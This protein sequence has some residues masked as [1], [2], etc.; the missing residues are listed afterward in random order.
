M[1]AKNCGG[2]KTS[3]V[4]LSVQCAEQCHVK[5]E[6]GGSEHLSAC[7][8]VDVALVSFHLPFSHLLY[9]A[10]LSFACLLCLSPCNNIG[11]CLNDVQ[12]RAGA[13]CH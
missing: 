3:T 9:L 8:E 2:A 11:T 1:Y 10:L 6:L 7:A 5:C 12:D 13:G 4:M